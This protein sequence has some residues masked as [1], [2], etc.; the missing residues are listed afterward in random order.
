MKSADRSIA[1][2]GQL[3]KAGVLQLENTFRSMLMDISKPIEP[4]A[5]IS[6]SESMKGGTVTVHF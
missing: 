5:Y 1:Q 4:L 6:K 2:M 3:L